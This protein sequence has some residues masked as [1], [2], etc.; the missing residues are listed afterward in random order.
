[1]LL[2]QLGKDQPIDGALVVPLSMHV[3]YWNNLG[4]PD[5]FAS[6]QFTDRQR[7]YAKKFRAH[8]VYTPQ[9][10]VDGQEQ[11][12]GSDREHARSA[13]A[14]SAGQREKSRVAID[15]AD[16]NER[17]C[18]IDLR[19]DPI[20]SKDAELFVAITEDDLQTS[21]LRGENAGRKLS[22]TAVARVLKSLGQPGEEM[23]TAS[24]E[25]ESGWRRDHLRVVA[26]VQEQ[27]TR[28][29]MAVGTAE[30]ARRAQE[31][32]GQK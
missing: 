19:V 10:I 15:I 13:I 27:S 2:A 18:R 5:P 31:P 6:Q 20:A 30:I 29:V 28:R 24:I 25:L 9:M 17:S 4:W 16:V 22:H 32:S 26:F 23:R 11:F 14:G 21:V 1:V 3:D 8:G 12:V 7:D